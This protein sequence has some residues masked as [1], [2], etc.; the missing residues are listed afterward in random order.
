MRSPRRSPLGV[1]RW[2]VW[3]LP[4]PV[5]AVIL[6]VEIVAAVVFAVGLQ[7]FQTPF[8]DNWQWL[9]LV[10]VGA[11]ILSTE[12]SLGV[13]RMRHRSD[14]SPHIDLSSVWAFAAA[15]LLPTA[16]ATVVVAAVYAH[17]YA[18]V[19]RRSGVPLHRVMFSTATVVLAVHAA[20]AVLETAGPAPFRTL[21]GLTAVVVALFAYAIVNM[22]LVVLVIVLSGPTRDLPTFLQVLGRGDE[23]VLEFATL[24]MGAL[25]AGAMASFGPAYAV[26]A[27]PPLIVL[28]RTVLVRQLEEAASID[29]KTGLL[30]AVTW[31][32][33]A[34][35]ALH[36]TER[37]E[38]HCGVL[39]LDL[40]EFKLVNDCWGHLAGDQVLVAVA[41]AVGAEVRDDDLVGRFGG[42]EFVVLLAGLDGDDGRIAAEAVAERIRR[43]VAALEVYVPGGGEPISVTVS[44]GGATHPADGIEL[45]DLLE[46]ADTAMYAA[47]SAGRNT[48]RMGLDGAS[49]TPTDR[50]ARS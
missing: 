46:V 43:R 19:W 4:R 41:G 18:R 7:G 13:E 24:S 32:I 2:A 15:A 35:R 3:S 40:D 42:E 44:I 34:T 22:L 14:E 48:V 21:A 31:Q 23:T 38:G 17:I 28:H 16:L 30:N 39:L 49:S 27:L 29:G 37:A 36:R 50:P 11:G 10:L 25:A 12:A 6:A 47:K 33:Q 20:R 26:L 8:P 45:E 5:L 1:S 9:L